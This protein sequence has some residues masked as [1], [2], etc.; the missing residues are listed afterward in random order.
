MRPPQVAGA[1]LLALL[2]VACSLACGGTKESPPVT[3]T[4]VP[5]RA[6]VVSPPSVT[7]AVGSTLALGAS[8]DADA[9]VT[10]RTVTWSSSDSSI[11]KVNAAGP[12]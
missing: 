7:V 1:R 4:G 2:S 3:G 10:V 8:I 5:V 12:S 9:S 6:V 11:A